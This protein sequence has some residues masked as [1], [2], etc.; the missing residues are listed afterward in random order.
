MSLENYVKYARTYVTLMNN[1][2]GNNTTGSTVE[3]I[4]FQCLKG[5]VAI[6][7]FAYDPLGRYGT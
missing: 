7:L 2:N 4:V 5:Q 3:E 6:Q 1:S